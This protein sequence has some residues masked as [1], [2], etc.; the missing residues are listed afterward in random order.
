VF[1]ARGARVSSRRP[2]CST[3]SARS[4]S[5]PWRDFDLT[6]RKLAYRL[7][8]FGVRPDVDATRTRRGYRLADLLDAFGRYLRPDPSNP[9]QPVR[10]PA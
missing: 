9:Y 3:G 10:H 1:G 8:G 2:T 7:R 4:T 5:A 6:A